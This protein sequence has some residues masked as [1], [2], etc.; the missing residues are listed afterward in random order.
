MHL[1]LSLTRRRKARRIADKIATV[2]IAA[3]GLAFHLKH[4]ENQSIPEDDF[5]RAYVYGA[6]CYAMTRFDLRGKA[7]T[8]GYIIWETYERLFPGKGQDLLIA[9]N[10]KAEAGDEEFKRVA[11]IG[12]EEMRH[13]L[14]AVDSGNL[15]NART[16]ESLTRQLTRILVGNN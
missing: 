4:D 12:F 7:E 14:E 9:F 6:T 15:E 11:D 8:K 16:L 5:V 10:R 3:S 1:L 13:V 2:V